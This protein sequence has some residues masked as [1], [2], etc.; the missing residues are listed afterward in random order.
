MVVDD[1]LQALFFATSS[2][3]THLHRS[4]PL[5]VLVVADLV[6]AHVHVVVGVAK[7]V[8]VEGRLKVLA[9]ASLRVHVIVVGGSLAHLLVTVVDAQGE[10]WA[11]GQAG[12]GLDDVGRVQRLG[13]D[14]DQVVV[15]AVEKF[16]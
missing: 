13:H 10:G 3:F 2:D 16:E 6:K 1:E 14:L 9:E 5:V 12:V 7:A 15:Q 4:L 11:R 8:L